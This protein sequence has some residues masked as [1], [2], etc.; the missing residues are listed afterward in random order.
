MRMQRQVGR[1]RYFLAHLFQLP[2]TRRAGRWNLRQY[3]FIGRQPWR[4]SIAE[5][6][7]ARLATGFLRLGLGLVLGEGSRLP[8][9]GALQPFDLSPQF[10]VLTNKLLD[11]SDQFFTAKLVEW[12]SGGQA[13]SPWTSSRVSHQSK[14]SPTFLFRASGTHSQA[15]YP[16]IS[17]A[18]PDANQL[19]TNDWVPC[20]VDQ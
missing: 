9:L 18:R 2:S 7:L 1:C 4:A 16:Y 14:H 15:A 19:R 12:R 20:A 13:L 8:V 6:S 10:V 17:P 11:Q 3:R 5:H